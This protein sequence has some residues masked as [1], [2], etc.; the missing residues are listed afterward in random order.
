MKGERRMRKTSWRKAFIG[1]AL[2]LALMIGVAPLSFSPDVYAQ[3]T[4]KVSLPFEY[5]GY[6]TTEYSSFVKMSKYAPMSDGVQLA[7][8]IFLPAGGPS[9]TKFPVVF[10]YTPYQRATINPA[11]GAI[12]DASLNS[13]AKLL[14]SYGYAFAVADMRGSGA[15]TGW[16]MDFMPEIQRD[17]GELVKWIAA[18]SWCDGNVGMTGGSYVG[19]SQMATAGQKPA[20]LKCILPEVIPLDGYTGEVYPGGVYLKAFLDLWTQGNRFQAN[21]YFLPSY[22]FFPTT[23]VVDEDNDGDLADEIPIDWNGNGTFLDDGPPTYKDGVVRKGNIYYNLTLEHYLYN[24]EYAGFAANLPFIDSVT[25]VGKTSYELGPNAFVPAMMEFGIPIYNAGGWFDGFA[26]GTTELY[27]TMA[28]TNPS[29]MLMRPSYHGGGGP[30]W[31]YLGIDPNEASTKMNIERLRYFE[32]CLKGIDN[33]IDKEP[34]I[35]IYVMN[36]G[37]WRFEDRWPLLEK[38]DTKYYF[39]ENHSLS[40]VKA[41]KG[42]DQYTADFSHDSRYGTNLGNR[43]LGVAGLAPNALPIRTQ[44]DGQTLLYTSKPMAQDTEVTGHPIVELYVSSTADYGDF[45]VYLEDV[46]Q[47]GQSILVTEGVLRAEWAKLYDTNEQIYSGK[48]GIEVLPKLPWHGY[49]Q[50]QYPHKPPLRDGRVV[51]LV[52]DLL[53]T[54]WVFKQGHRIQASIACADW[55]TFKLHEKLSPNN[56]PIDP[57][58]IVPTVTVYRD[59][60]HHSSISLPVIPRFHRVFEGR[61]K[62]MTHGQWYD[63]PATLYTFRSAMYLHLGDRWIKWADV[64]YWKVGEVGYYRG[65]G[66]LGKIF[67]AVLPNEHGTFSAFAVGRKVHFTGTAK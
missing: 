12:R 57:A 6:S 67:T 43:L 34:P 32:R 42:S 63:G 35:Y 16:K 28:G 33:G 18:Q 58:N 17:G 65:D 53:P 30:F 48:Y 29:K 11:T 62:I 26:R 49:E 23:P 3:G 4:A 19:W 2:V 56:K 66:D 31:Q 44:K 1:F 59:S 21:N 13:L 24:V 15:S 38:V 60:K 50:A 8:D 9:R 10:Q 22:G 54:S 41:T 25:P 27:N 5:S 47:Q 37:S 14:L 36:S 61:A 7:V 20:A 40:T 46:D 45:F 55:P 64:D 39:E 52:F 51:K